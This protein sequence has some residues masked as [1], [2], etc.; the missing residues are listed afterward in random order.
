VTQRD[1]STGVSAYPRSAELFVEARRVI[2]GGVTSAIRAGAQPHP[3]YIERGSGASIWDADGNRYVDYALGYGPLILG[4]A[5][6]LV[7]EAIGRQLE[8]GTTFGS[9]SRLE[10]EVAQLILDLV[11]GAEQVIFS[12]T[13]TEAVASAMRVARAAT[14]RS[15]V[16]RFEG[17]YHGWFDGILTGIA[18]GDEPQSQPVPGS[19][20]IPPAA[21]SDLLVAPWNDL[22]AVRNLMADHRGQIAAII[23]E[24]LLVNG[25][26]IHPVPEFLAGLRD[27]A[28]EHGSVLIFDEVI[29]GFR[30]APGGAQ[31]R[32][33]IQADLA[34][35]GKAMGAGVAISAVAGRRDVLEVV[36]DGVVV[37]NGTFNGNVLALAA[38]AATLTHLRD[39][40]DTVFPRLE[41]LG[42]RLAAG[43]RALGTPLIV[44]NLGP[45]VHTAIG[46]PTD[47]R[48]VRDRASGDIAA[49]SAFV[50]ELLPRG[51]HGT[52]RGL[53]YV[54]TAHTEAEIDR[55]IEAAAVALLAALAPD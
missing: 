34:V 6:A 24:P 9:Q 33:G 37:H 21:Q 50:E 52:P 10:I 32:Y 11:P 40:R 13:G 18:P 20:G 42:D 41:A 30:I 38:A 46:E 51:V 36:S 54:S 27:L 43:L 45:I 3:L 19:G 5:P 16:L 53:W 39:G 26:L 48:S 25:G 17:H 47:V 2:A 8:L 4:H 35:F 7:R 22:T 44:R 15:L 1:D 14:G 23:L 49:H 55:T 28:T 29:T 12:T 31:E